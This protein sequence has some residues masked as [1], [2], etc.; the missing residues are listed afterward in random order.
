MNHILTRRAQVVG[1]GQGV[2]G[3]AAIDPRPFLVMARLV[4]TYVLSLTWK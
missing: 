1:F 2:S 3:G 4:V